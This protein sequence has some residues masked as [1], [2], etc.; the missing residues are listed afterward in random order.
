MVVST[1]ESAPQTSVH[2]SVT[3]PGQ[4][5]GSDES[6]LGQAA[7]KSQPVASLGPQ[8]SPGK[9]SVLRQ[10]TLLRA[11]GPLKCM[12]V[13]SMGRCYEHNVTGHNYCTAGLGYAVATALTSKNLPS[14]EAKGLAAGSTA[15][16]TLG[17]QP[18]DS[19]CAAGR[20]TIAMTRMAVQGELHLCGRSRQRLA[21][22]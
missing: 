13:C 5:H 6:A 18:A 10:G 19:G 8:S 14:P 3:F 1:S 20:Q 22:T 15:A 21:M 17:A 7:L 2:I 4:T 16:A 11:S 12:S 9:P